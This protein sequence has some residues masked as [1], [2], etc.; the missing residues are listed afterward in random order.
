VFDG[1]KYE[2]EA[3]KFGQKNWSKWKTRFKK[4]GLL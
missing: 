4:E 2:I 1:N 3:E